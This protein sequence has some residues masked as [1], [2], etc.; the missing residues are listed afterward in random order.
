MK[1]LIILTDENFQFLISIPDLKNYV[2]M[3]ID[4]IKN[5]FIAKEYSVDVRKFSSLDLSAGYK[6]VYIIY[7]TS[8][9]PGGFYK[10]YIEDLV[11]VLEQKGAVV[12]PN[13]ELLMAHH[14]KV[15]MEMMRSGFA[16]NALRSVQS[17]CYGSWVDAENYNEVFPAVVKRSS[18]SGSAGVFLASNRKEYET[19]VKR[20]GKVI[21]GQSIRRIFLNYLKIS[22]KKIIKYLY[23]SK[24]NYIEYNTAPVS[25]S[26]VVQPFIENLHGDFK[27]LIFGSRY[28]TL[29][30]QNRENDFRASGSGRFFDVPIEEHEGLL[31]FARKVTGEI[32]FPIFGLDIAFDTK[33][34][35]LLEF[36]VIHIGTPPLQRSRYWH[37]Y[38][39]GKWVKID[40]TSVLEEEF[41]RSMYEYINI[42]YQN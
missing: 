29:Y 2:S 23:P 38:H 15:F 3:D 42:K 25:T 33:A 35:H 5:Y 27:V 20:A 6:G 10:R 1:R 36:Q 40:G 31:N 13:H 30:R 16:D 37:E 4:K 26:I 19:I 9:T 7:Q 39:N 18:G 32:D 11:W 41:S 24:S 17:R 22:V 8:E 28:Y 34:Y 14:N 21:I 12:L